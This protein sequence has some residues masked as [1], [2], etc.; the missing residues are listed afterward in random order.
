M[1][2]RGFWVM[3]QK[4]PGA[5]GLV[6]PEGGEITRGELYAAQNQ[7]VHGRRGLCLLYTSPGPRGR[8]G[9]CRRRI[10]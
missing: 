2:E 3:A 7:L 10:R 1:A 4:D 5:L 9:A 8:R 6:T